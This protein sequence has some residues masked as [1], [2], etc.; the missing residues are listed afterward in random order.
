MSS[1]AFKRKL[2][3]SIDGKAIKINRTTTSGTLIHTAVSGTVDGT[4]DEIWLW[5]Y[6]DYTSNVELTVEFGGTSIPDN[7]IT[8]SV[9]YKAGL[10]PIIPGMLL[11]NS[12]VVSA[13]ATTANII[14]INGFVN[15][16]TD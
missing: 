5:A 7:V 1:S 12:A 16:I 6:N 15:S 8:V 9:P 2:T 3:G 14:T 4:Y 13:F 10:V 11:Q